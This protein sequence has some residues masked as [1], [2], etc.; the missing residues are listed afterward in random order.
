MESQGEITH[1]LVD[2]GRSLDF[3]EGL[4]QESFPDPL[5]VLDALI[6]IFIS[7]KCKFIFHLG[8]NLSSLDSWPAPSLSSVISDSCPCPAPGSGKSTGCLRSGAG[9]AGRWHCRW[10]DLDQVP[11][12][13]SLDSINK[14][15]GVRRSQRSFWP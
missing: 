4:D 8:Q 11:A 2:P 14:G 9:T 5:H 6:Y 12:I 15:G 7:R 13:A 10:C 3:P 1:H